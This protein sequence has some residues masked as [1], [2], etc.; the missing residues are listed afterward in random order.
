[1]LKPLPCSKPCIDFV[2]VVVV[3]VGGAIAV[4]SRRAGLRLAETTPI[5]GR[6]RIPYVVRS[7]FFSTAF[8][9]VNIQ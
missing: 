6:I 3:L 8:S 2:Y 5:V 7:K 9:Y 1:M 4:K